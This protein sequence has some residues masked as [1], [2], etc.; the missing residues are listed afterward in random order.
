V[1]LCELEASMVYIA[2]SRTA[3]MGMC[4]SMQVTRKAK[5]S[6]EAVVTGSCE[7]PDLGAGN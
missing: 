5:R 4:L 6:S 1:D 2:G 3:R 7:A